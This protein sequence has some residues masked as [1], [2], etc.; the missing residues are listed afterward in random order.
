MINKIICWFKGHDYKR[1]GTYQEKTSC[2]GG[3][4]FKC[5]SCGSFHI[6]SYTEIAW[7]KS[8]FKDCHTKSQFAKMLEIQK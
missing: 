1:I 3:G 6:K 5:R 2:V 4:L 7:E 8:V